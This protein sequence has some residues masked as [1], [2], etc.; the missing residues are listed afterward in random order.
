MRSLA[1]LAGPDETTFVLMDDRAG[2]AAVAGL[3]VANLDL[4]GT[5]AFL[6]VLKRDHGLVEAADAWTT[7]MLIAGPALDRGE[8]AD[9]VLFRA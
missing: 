7:M 4:M 1:D 9:P 5:A 3:G 6:R 8:E 2:R